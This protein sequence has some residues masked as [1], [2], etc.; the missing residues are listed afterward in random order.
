MFKQCSVRGC[1]VVLIFVVFGIYRELFFCDG[2]ILSKGKITMCVKDKNRDPYNVVE[3]KGC[4]KKLVITKSV[5]AEQVGVYMQCL[6]SYG[7]RT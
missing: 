2:T 7:K 6:V 5:S 3:G 1:L 4:D